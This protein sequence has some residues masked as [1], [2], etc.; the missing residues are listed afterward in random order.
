MIAFISVQVRGFPEKYSVLTRSAPRIDRSSIGNVSTDAARPTSSRSTDA[1]DAAPSSER[2]VID[3]VLDRLWG[4]NGLRLLI[5]MI[6]A[7]QTIGWLMAAI[8][9]VLICRYL[10]IPATPIVAWSG[11]LLIASQVITVAILAYVARPLTTISPLSSDDQQRRA[12]EVPDRVLNLCFTILAAFVL[13]SHLILVLWRIDLD[14]PTFLLLVIAGIQV[15][16]AVAW[17]ALMLL[18]WYGRVVR[19]RVQSVTGRQVAVV[20]K[21]TVRSRMIFALAPLALAAAGLGM[22]LFVQPDVQPDQLLVRVVVLNAIGIAFLCIFAPLFAR[23][24]TLP[25]RE[26][27]AG[28]E[29]LKHADFSTPVPELASDE[30]GVLA[31]TLNEAMEGMADRRRLAKEVRASRSRIVTAADESRKRIERNIH[32]GA[33]QR[34]VALALDMR[35]L[36]E[37]APTMSPDE[38]AAAHRRIGDGLKAALSELRELARGLHPSVLT[39]DGL[40]PAVEQLASRSSI[41]VTVDVT[42]TRFPEDVETAC[43]FTVAEALANVAKYAEATEASVHIAQQDGGIRLQV[44][45]NGVGGANPKAGSGLTGLVDRVAALDG[46]LIVDSPA[47]VGTTLTVELPIPVVTTESSEA[48][49]ASP[50]PEAPKQPYGGRP[51]NSGQGGKARH[52]WL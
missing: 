32:D 44:S 45:D 24:V 8:A 5:V 28:A 2:D 16:L 46:T 36:E 9:E 20:S 27:T 23:S 12:E 25:L 21:W 48:L 51:G 3:R 34:L 7:G 22:L 10:G 26:L 13:P 50:E 11:A 18:P 33:Q 42:E 41:P 4:R 1:I 30:F 19:Y 37:Q 31:R 6:V 49:R 40:G 15:A 35:M 38:L 43:Y 17:V 14:L 47:G 29:R 52:Q 39:T